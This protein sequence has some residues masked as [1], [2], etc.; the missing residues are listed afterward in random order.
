MDGYKRVLNTYP[1]IQIPHFIPYQ[2]VL[3][4][5]IIGE[6]VNNYSHPIESPQILA[7]FY[8]SHGDIV[9]TKHEYAQDNYLKPG[10]AVRIHHVSNSV[11]HKVCAYYHI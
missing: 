2:D 7:S 8:D 9:E 10:A 1:H 6:V 3:Y 4:S 11:K 5:S